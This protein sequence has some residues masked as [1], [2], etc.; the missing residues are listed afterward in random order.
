M[1]TF[2]QNDTDSLICIPIEYLRKAAIELVEYDYCQIERDSLRLTIGDLSQIISNKDSIIQYEI[3]LK[4]TSFE[5]IDSLGYTVSTLNT[6]IDIL[7]KDNESL[8][9]ERNIL[10]GIIASA[11]TLMGIL[12]SV[13]N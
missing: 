10:R 1:L 7:N 5:I 12:F 6:H 2:S 9:K 4:E 3:K 11:G 8:K 13:L